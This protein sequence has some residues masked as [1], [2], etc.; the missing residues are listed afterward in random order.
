MHFELQTH[1][2]V[3]IPLRKF[4]LKILLTTKLTLAMSIKI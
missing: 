1:T 4:W 3:R 2:A